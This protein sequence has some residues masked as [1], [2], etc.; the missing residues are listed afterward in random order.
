MRKVKT[1]YGATKYRRDKREKALKQQIKAEKENAQRFAEIKRSVEEY[2]RE[3]DTDALVKYIEQSS[4]PPRLMAAAKE[5][6]IGKDTLVEYLVSM[7]YSREDLKPTAKLTFGGYVELIKRYDR[8]RLKQFELNSENLVSQ[9]EEIAISFLDGK[10]IVRGLKADGSVVW[11]T[12]LDTGSGLFLPVF[13]RYSEL[14]KEFEELIN[15]NNVTEDALQKFLENNQEFIN[16]ANHKEVIPQALIV[17]E[18]HF[19]E[20]DF[21]L[22]PFDECEFCK[23]IELKLPNVTLE[24]SE[25]NGHPR[26]TSKLLHAIQQLKD[27][28][29]AFQSKETR[30][31]FQERYG[32]DVYR[33]DL[34]LVIGRKGNIQF[35]DTFVDKQKDEGI[36]ITDWDTFLEKAKRRFC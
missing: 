10:L 8:D 12:G 3:Y 17:T 27:Y 24:R 14:I 34:Q 32:T 22:I 16:E 30:K 15:D 20:A 7:G 29:K 11:S 19:W 9:P 5:F 23:I 25:K 2:K 21:V 6:D 26:F 4:N 36:R 13:N 31:K 18:D 35:K 28:A 33:P 1:G